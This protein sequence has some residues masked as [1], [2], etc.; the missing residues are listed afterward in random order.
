MKKEE[1]NLPPHLQ[2]IAHE[3]QKQDE[4]NSI[5]TLSQAVRVLGDAK[6][7]LLEAENA[8][9]Q[10]LSQWR[11]FLQQSVVKWRKFSAS[12]H[13]SES[14]HQQGVMAAKQAVKPAQKTLDIGSKKEQSG[15]EGTVTIS[16]DEADKDALDDVMEGP[17][18]ES[19]QRI[20][21]GMDSIVTSLE[22]LSTSADQLEQ[23]VKRPRVS[24]PDGN[25]SSPAPP[26]GTAGAVWRTRIHTRGL[27]PGRWPAQKPWS[28]NGHIQSSL[29]ETTSM[30]GKHRNMRLR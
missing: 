23:R 25:A 17:H 16:D 26:F 20:H 27:L 12:F 14:A 2:S 13:A 5:K 9:A 29:K 21:Q 28:Y 11:L 8:R 3:M 10:L 7:D 1:D 30:S 6:Q 22:E 19:V 18:N 4:K 24:A 15:K